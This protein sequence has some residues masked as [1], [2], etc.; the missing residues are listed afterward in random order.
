MGFSLVLS[1]QTFEL[2]LDLQAASPPVGRL[3][4]SAQH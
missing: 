2:G 1:D 3:P 4:F